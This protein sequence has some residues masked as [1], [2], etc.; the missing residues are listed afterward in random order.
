MQRNELRARFGFLNS[1]PLRVCVLVLLTQRTCAKCDG[2]PKP[3]R[4]HHC[5]I[6][7]TCILKMDHRTCARSHSPRL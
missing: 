7:G 2:A 3:L 6:C 1:V 4:T 5:S